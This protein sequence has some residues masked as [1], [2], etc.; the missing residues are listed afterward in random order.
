[1]IEPLSLDLFLFF[2]TE[3]VQRTT[4][5]DQ[6]AFA[7]ALLVTLGVLSA[8]IGTVAK[9]VWG[10]SILNSPPVKAF[11]IIVYFVLPMMSTMAFSA[12]SCDDV[13]QSGELQG[14]VG[15]GRRER[16]GRRTHPDTHSPPST[17]QPSLSPPCPVQV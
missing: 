13:S 10:G 1:M 9:A 11:I 4:Y 3:C 2:H 8:A 17:P 15:E 6:L 16:G 12:F 5:T 7:L 14:G